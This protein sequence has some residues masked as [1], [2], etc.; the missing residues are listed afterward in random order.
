MDV[1]TQAPSYTSLRKGAT[2]APECPRCKF[3]KRDAERAIEERETLKASLRSDGGPAEFW[4]Q[5]A[6]KVAAQF[7]DRMHRHRNL[8]AKFA[9][10][11]EARRQ[12]IAE[13]DALVV[14]GEM[15]KRELWDVWSRLSDD[16]P[17]KAELWA[18]W[19]KLA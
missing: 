3:W 8:E 7:K 14:R 4:R 16:M 10:E 19:S 2:R 5:E 1:T 15:V 6:V 17:A 12:A 13:R 11:S 18:V 9:D